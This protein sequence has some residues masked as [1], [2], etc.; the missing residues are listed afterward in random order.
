MIG[1]TASADLAQNAGDAQLNPRGWVVIDQVNGKTYLDSAYLRGTSYV[2]L[3]QLP[4][5]DIRSEAKQSGHQV[6]ID[7]HTGGQ[8]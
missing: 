8:E 7:A 4:S 5:S 1:H 2:F 6:K 3:F